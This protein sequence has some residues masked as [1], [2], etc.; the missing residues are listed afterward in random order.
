MAVVVAAAETL[1][2][3]DGVILEG[4][5]WLAARAAATCVAAPDADE[6][7]KANAG[8]QLHVWRLDYGV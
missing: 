5:V 6:A 4:S 7:T 1:L 2:E 8:Q 3:Q